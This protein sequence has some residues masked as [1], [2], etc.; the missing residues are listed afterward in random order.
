VIE[1]VI[2]FS[3]TSMPILALMV[4]KLTKKKNANGLGK[5]K[6]VKINANG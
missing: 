5:L 1:I 6:V 2:S 4:H 3:V